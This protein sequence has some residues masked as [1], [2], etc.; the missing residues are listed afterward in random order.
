[1]DLGTFRV[2]LADPGKRSFLHHLDRA[3][4]IDSTPFCDSIFPVDCV[5]CFLLNWIS[6]LSG[7][8]P[9]D[10]DFGNRREDPEAVGGCSY[11]ESKTNP[12]NNPPI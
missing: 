9:L 1:M 4:C 7:Q 11:S 12:P 10:E 2:L 5:W 6:Q 3:Q 8:T